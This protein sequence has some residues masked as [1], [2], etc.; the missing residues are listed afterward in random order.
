MREDLWRAVCIDDGQA[1]NQHTVTRIQINND[2]KK[3]TVVKVVEEGRVG[4]PQMDILR[5][6]KALRSSDIDVI[7]VVP[8][9]D[10]DKFQGLLMPVCRT[11]AM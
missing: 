5:T 3:L 6:S 9:A 2:S 4:G 8:R 11:L 10:S 7:V 1:P